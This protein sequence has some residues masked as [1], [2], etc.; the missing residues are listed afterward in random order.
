M[1]SLR[2][3]RHAFKADCTCVELHGFSDVSNKANGGCIYIR[4]VG[5][6]YND[7][8]LNVSCSKS[9]VALLKPITVPKLEL[10]GLL[11][12][13]KLMKQ[14]V[15]ALGIHHINMYVMWTD[16][17][18][19]LGWLKNTTKSLKSSRCKQSVRDSRLCQKC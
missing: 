4:T 11:I 6:T 2:V 15:E 18:V 10:C 9:R 14:T 16:S 17:S 8:S 3:P 5:V 13:A 12:L 19:V 7:I 1:N